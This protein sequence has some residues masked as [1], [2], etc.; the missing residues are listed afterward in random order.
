MKGMVKVKNEVYQENM[1][2]V[3]ALMEAQKNVQLAGNLRK[4]VHIDFT[5]P[6]GNTYKGDVTFKRLTVGDM[7]RV[8]ALVAE[9]FRK[10]GVTDIRFID[11]NAKF[12]AR[13]MAT[14]RV[15]MVDMQDWLRDMEKLTEIEIIYHVYGQYRNWEDSFLVRSAATASDDGSD[16]EGAEALDA[17]EASVR[18]NSA[19]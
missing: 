14:L 13:V 1:E 16:S 2:K 5:S 18:G 15:A 11:E 4:T 8:E 9:Y 19:D 12:H 10:A 17:S 3:K 6:E 7:L